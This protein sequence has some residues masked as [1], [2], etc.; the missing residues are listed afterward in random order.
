MTQNQTALI[1]GA[2]S[3]IGLSLAKIFARE[4]YS[5]V[6]VARNESKLKQLAGELK[7]PITVIPKD[8]SLPD[9]QQEI[10]DE[11]NSKSISVDVLVNNAGFGTYGPFS[12]TPLTEGL[13]M[14]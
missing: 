11:L 3:G 10:Y 5:L 1:T 8:L 6:L 14:L 9:S 2:S 13:D 12:E 7:V 4:G